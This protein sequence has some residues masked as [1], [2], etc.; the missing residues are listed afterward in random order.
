MVRRRR[1]HNHGGLRPN[2]YGRR[3]RWTIG[4]NRTCCQE[5]GRGSV[6]GLTHWSR[7]AWGGVAPPRESLGR[8]QEK[9]ASQVQKSRTD[10]RFGTSYRAPLPHTEG[11][12]G[13]VVASH[14]EAPEDASGSEGVSQGDGRH[15]G[16]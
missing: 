3:G 5:Y 16:G 12:G 9:H 2:K 7:A 6:P 10:G 15:V 1:T 4:V 13:L 11:G 14:S 8:R